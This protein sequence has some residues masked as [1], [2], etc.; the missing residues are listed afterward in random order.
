MVRTMRSSVYDPT[1]SV[2][3]AVTISL[4]FVA[5]S[6]ALLA[7]NDSDPES[8]ATTSNATG[9]YE[10]SIQKF[11]LNWSQT[12]WDW[13]S[14]ADDMGHVEVIVSDPM[15]AYGVLSS[16][17]ASFESL[18]R[19]DTNG[20]TDTSSTHRDF[21]VGFRGFSAHLSIEV[22]DQLLTTNPSL[23]AY[24]DLPV[25][26]TVSGNLV[27]VGAD[28]VWTYHD[29]YGKTVKGSGIT[30][31]VID[32]GVDYT[33]PDLGG[34]FGA[35]YKV[36]GGYDFFNNDANPIDDNGHGTHVAGII[37]ANG[38]SYGVAPE[39]SILAYKVLG[40]DGWGRMSTVISGI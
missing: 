21:T 38:G 27:Q 8:S 29:S 11:V 18:I 39:A 22:L 23:Q 13:P 1:L 16:G 12:D 15:S 35:G 2:I 40:A 30:V 20:A 7:T 17:G 3:L 31:A 10:P 5:T 32:T 33:H 14:L 34:G 28:Q 37:A 24:P 25:K 6:F 4:L 9:S 36:V 19:D 26:I